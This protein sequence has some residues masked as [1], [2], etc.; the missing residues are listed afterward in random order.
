MNEIG[1]TLAN[2]NINQSRHT[3]F[4]HFSR[5]FS[6][7]ELRVCAPIIHTIIKGVG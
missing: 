3:C 7:K 2:E 4:S 5:N 6:Q 1:V